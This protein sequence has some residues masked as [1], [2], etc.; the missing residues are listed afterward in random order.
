MSNAY[1]FFRGHKHLI[2]HADHLFGN[3]NLN[4]QQFCR[5]ILEHIK[6]GK[7]ISLDWCPI[8]VFVDTDS[9]STSGWQSA[10]YVAFSRLSLVYFGLVENFDNIIDRTNVKK[11]NRSLLFGS[12]LFHPSFW[13]IFAIR[14]WLMIMSGFYPFVFVMRCQQKSYQK[15]FS[16]KREK[17]I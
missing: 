14:S 10:Q 8:A 15:F 4:Y 1:A 6:F 16:Q 2:A 13:S 17:E 9:I 7:D 11:N 3:K 12:F 5:I